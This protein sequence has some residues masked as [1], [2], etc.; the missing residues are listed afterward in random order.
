MDGP[1]LTDEPPHGDNRENEFFPDIS[2]REPARSILEAA[3]W[4]LT[5][6]LARR[7]PDRFLVIETHPGGGQYDCITLIDED[8]NS[9]LSR[10]DLN[11]AGSIWVHRLDHSSWTWRDCWQELVTADDLRPLLDRLR[12]QAGLPPVGL[13]PA[14]RLPRSTR[15]VVTYRMIAAFLAHQVF[16]RTRWQ[17]LNGYL[18]SSG[19]SGGVRHQF[20]D[21]FPAAR[22]RMT[23]S[24]NLFDDGGQAASGFWFLVKNDVPKLAIEPGQ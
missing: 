24:V 15:S 8:K 11:R 6:E 1:S 21:E 5:A 7:Y 9:I 14:D 22:E 20:F 23:N 3:S 4:R 2:D 12:V 19:M 13:A 10:I 17:C 18:D 16:S